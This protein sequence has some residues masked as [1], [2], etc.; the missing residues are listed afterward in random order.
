[1]KK[2]QKILALVLSL[3]LLLAIAIPAAADFDYAA[4]AK[5]I[6]SDYSGKTVIL[7][8]N[9]VHGA[10]EGYAAMSALR[11]TFE[12]S[13]AEVILVDAGDFSQGTI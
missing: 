8:S 12:M 4:N 5:V 3:I 1:M 10:L 2:S 6:Y 11:A 7:H 9:D 13:G